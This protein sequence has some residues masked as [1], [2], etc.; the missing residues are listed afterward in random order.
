MQVLLIALL[1]LLEAAEPQK[2]VVLPYPPYPFKTYLV[3]VRGT[4]KA[5]DYCV[6]CVDAARMD[7]DRLCQ[8]KA[9][10]SSSRML[11]S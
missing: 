11:I 7:R 3:G 6:E 1:H 9:N 10:C 8:S 2:T 5:D 4:K